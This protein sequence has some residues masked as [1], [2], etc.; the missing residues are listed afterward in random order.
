MFTVQPLE[1]EQYPHH[2]LGKLYH[3]SNR[4]DKNNNNNKKVIE[5]MQMG[6]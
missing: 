2:H 4:G 6:G 1:G 5:E 3:Y